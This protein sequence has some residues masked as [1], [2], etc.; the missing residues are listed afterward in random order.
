M[1][2]AAK[3]SEFYPQFRALG[4][5]LNPALAKRAWALILNVAKPRMSVVDHE[6]TAYL[7]CTESTVLTKRRFH[8]AQ[9]LEMATFLRRER[10]LP[11][12]V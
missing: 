2:I 1:R 7:A 6:F 9:F 8:L 5:I 11:V 10:G 4:R 3:V 12:D